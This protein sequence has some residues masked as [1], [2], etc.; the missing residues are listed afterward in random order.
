[1]IEVL[2]VFFG[3]VFVGVFIMAIVNSNGVDAPGSDPHE[4][5]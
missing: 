2:C 5:V 4:G 1:M 3:G